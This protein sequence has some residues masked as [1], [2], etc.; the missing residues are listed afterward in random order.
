MTTL[1]V[2]RLL[3]GVLTS[4]DTAS[5]SVV[6]AYGTTVLAPT[7]VTP[8]SAGIYSYDT[9]ALQA[10]SYTATW[11]FTTAG[12]MTDT[13]SR[14]FVIDA[15]VE[16]TEGVTLMELERLV[17]RRIGPYRRLRVGAG[18]TV[19]AVYAARLKSSLTLGSYEEQY[20]LRRGLTFG[21][22]LV[23]N[24]DAGDRTRLVTVYDASMGTLAVDRVYTVAAVVDEAVELHVL[25]PEDE[26]RP[27]VL[28]ALG[29]CFFWDTVSLTVTASGVYN[30]NLSAA[31]PWL[32]Q[33]NQIREVSLAYPSQL[34]PPRRLGWWQPYRSGKDLFLYTK[35]GAVGS[36]TIQA[37][38]PVSSLVNGELSLGGPND[39]LDIVYVD[40]DYAAW[41]G[42]LEC[43]KNHP[44][45]LQPL[46]TQS[47]RPSR[48]DAAIEFTKKSLTIV[49]QVPE[50]LQLDYGRDDIVQIGNLAEPA[51]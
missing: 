26:L 25:D 31:A 42:V 19:N 9:S 11:V 22:E 40:K 44:E 17:A 23:T 32:T 7:L 43:W 18:S 15:A 5:L 14:A 16:L 20:V 33:V 8:I 24:Y 37:L 36:V 1:A 48:A 50:T 27:S 21:D 28:D 29:R 34:M 6:D 47:M 13:I 51:I 49:Q 30:I 4:A 35:G 46:A 39:D 3:D 41:A 12:L 10:G 2:Q 38:R 45:T